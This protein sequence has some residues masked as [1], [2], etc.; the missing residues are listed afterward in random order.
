MGAKITVKE[1]TQLE[2]H[3]QGV[4][5]L[6]NLRGSSV[7]VSAGGDGAVVKWDLDENGPVRMNP[8]PSVAGVLFAQLPEPV[9]C[10]MEGLEG[11]IWAGTQG[12]LVFKLVSGEAPRMIKLGTSSVFFISRWMD[13]RIAVGLGSG[14]LVFLDDELQL[15]DRKSLGKKSLRCCLGD[16][17]LIGGSDGLIWR[18]DAQ[19]DI[20]KRW[21]ANSPS[22][23]C[24]AEDAQGDIVSGGRD[25]LLM[26]MGEDGGL[27]QEVKA[28]L[29]TIHALAGSDLGWLASGS[30]DK[31]V[32]VWD[33]NSGALLKVI[34]REKYPSRGHSHSV[35]AL[36]WVGR[37][38][39][40]AGDDKIIRIW[41][42]SV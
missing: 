3:K 42:V 27:K 13:G 37:L 10:L 41:E 7:I 17:G 36:C 35:N 9:F 4:Y 1:Y 20:L 18:L 28:H 31:T 24:L 15:L 33:R 39:A 25:A 26:W 22:V 8:E 32:K 40:S 2:G 30:M 38:L 21:D 19:G 29:F 34:D 6:L 11:V 16:R 23:F 14:E 12:G 5:A